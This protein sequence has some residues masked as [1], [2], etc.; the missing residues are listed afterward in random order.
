MSNYFAL[1]S[2][3][4]FAFAVMIAHAQNNNHHHDETQS[5]ASSA[6]AA[7]VAAS[8]GGQCGTAETDY[9]PCLGRE[10]ADTLFRHCCQQYAPEGCQSLCTYESDELTARNNLLQSVKAG[11]CDLKHVSTILYCASQN[12]DN[13]KC[14]DH[15]GLG[16][17]KLGVG[18]RCLRFCDPAGE[19]IGSISR[20][21]VTCLFNWNVINYCS[22]SGIK[23]E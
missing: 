20:Q 22:H 21:D 7:A 17:P 13:R 3:C 9:A 23:L 8:E 19:G 10:R 18:K 11:K 15:L 2:A 14:C 6:A 16:D 4:L 5:D 12:Q 1:I